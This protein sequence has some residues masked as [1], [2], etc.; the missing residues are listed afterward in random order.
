LCLTGRENSLDEMILALGLDRPL[1]KGA[2]PV[3]PRPEATP[4]R[5]VMEADETGRASEVPV[6]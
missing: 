3:S 2:E 6:P 4:G 1:A 5:T